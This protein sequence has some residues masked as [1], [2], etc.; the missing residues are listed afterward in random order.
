MVGMYERLGSWVLPRDLEDVR[1]DNTTLYN[2]YEDETP[3]GD[4]FLHLYKEIDPT[5]KVAD[6]YL[7]AEILLWRRDQM[8]RGH[9]VAQK[10]E[11]KGNVMGWAHWN[12]Y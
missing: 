5:P 3:N 10:R 7:D 4:T 8:T 9:V 6:Q 2:L 1:L 11:T 12:P